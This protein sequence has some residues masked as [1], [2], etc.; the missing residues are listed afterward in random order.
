MGR[1]REDGE[2]PAD[3]SDGKGGRITV[4]VDF[5]ERSNPELYT[6][7]IAVAPGKQRAQRVRSLMLKGHMVELMQASPAHRAPRPA[8]AMSPSG[9]G[10]ADVFGP[11]LE[12]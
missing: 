7:V 9:S 11:P 2:A 5:D 10:A 8:P 4:T 1:A 6:T 3:G 12:G